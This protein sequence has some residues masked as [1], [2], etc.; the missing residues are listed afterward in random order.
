M[1]PRPVLSTRLASALVV[2]VA[3]SGCVTAPAFDVLPSGTAPPAH[4]VAAEPQ[5][6]IDHPVVWGGMIL[7][8][9]N[10]EHH[11][12]IEMLGYPMDD[13][14]RPLLELPDEGRFIALLPG[15]VEARN[16]PQGRFL[17]LVGRITGERRGSIRSAEYVWPEVDVDRVYLWPRDFRESG[18]RFSFGV[19]VGVHL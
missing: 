15:Y 19:G 11:S 13:K 3:L 4:R 5:R 14:Q 16:Y 1:T 7:E 6:W 2:A 8:V 17:S 9:R 18:S 12:E 10:F